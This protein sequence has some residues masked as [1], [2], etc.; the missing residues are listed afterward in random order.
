MQAPAPAAAPS[1]SGVIGYPPA[2]FADVRPTSAFDM[3]LRLPGF[4]FDRGSTVRGLAGSGGNVLIDGRPP[5]SK[6]DQ[7]EDILRRIPAAAVARVEVIRGGAQG[8]D[9][10]GRTVLAN[11]VR[12]NVSGFR[13]AV[14]PYFDAVYDGR[15]L[16]GIRLEQQLS[17]P[18]GR[19][20][21]LSQT[22][23]TGHFPN[24]EF[25]DGRR[26]RY[27]AA[28]LPI[29]DSDVDADSH[30][31]RLGATGAFQTPLF[32]G[33]ANLTGAVQRNQGTTEIY[34]N[35]ELSPR[36]EYEKSP[37]NRWQSEV[38]LRFDRR[39]TPRVGLEALLFQQYYTQDQ[40]SHFEAPGLTRDF[41]LDRKTSES[42]ARVQV[43]ITASPDLKL[44]AGTEGAYNRLNSKTTLTIN[45]RAVALPAGDVVVDEL[46]G[47]GFLRGTWRASPQLTLEAGVREETSRVTSA[48]DLTLSK[49]LTFLKPRAALTW[50]PDK[51]TQVR[52]RVEREVGQLNFDDFVASPQVASTGVVVSGNPDLSPLQA[53]VYE[54]AVERRFWGSA[55]VGLTYRRFD[56]SDVVDRAP[57]FGPGGVILADAPGNIGNGTKTEVQ[58]SLT[59]PLDKLGLPSAQFKGQATWRDTKVIDPLGSGVRQISTLHPIDWEA[60]FSH[61]IPDWRMSWGVDVLGGFR[62]RVFR[63]TEIETKKLSPMVTLYT[64]NRLRPDLTL[65]FEFTGITMRNAKRIREVYVGPRSLGVLNYTDVRD[66]EW[67]GDIAVRLR[68]TFGG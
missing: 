15:F 24:D 58:A 57:I 9:M 38:G 60:H 63:L 13:G 23:S 12:Q 16:P 18:G 52:L 41:A 7:L 31:S 36:V 28:G 68:K 46:R 48:G 56:L 26:V 47:E 19:T 59:L 40:K 42:V 49:S 33:R 8:V 22:L 39:L 61:A 2:F 43:N 27:T 30:G 6:N 53:W 35:D 55:V 29:I 34:D 66:L 54:A 1:E 17:L 65:R 5:L 10:E 11:V 50:S 3:V 4:S 44:E 45:S 25:G 51:L 21:E 67:G 20:L 14:Q 62:E 32:G 64:E 37:N